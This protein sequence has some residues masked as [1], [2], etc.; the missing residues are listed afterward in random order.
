MASLLL[1]TI[2][3]VGKGSKVLKIARK[4]GMIGALF[5]MEKESC[6]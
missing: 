2:V 5:S 3:D 1:T 4:H 6:Q